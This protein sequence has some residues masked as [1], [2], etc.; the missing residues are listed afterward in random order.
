M[1]LSYASREK[2][3]EVWR[4]FW[5][6]VI[7]LEPNG[8]QIANTYSLNRKPSFTSTKMIF[9]KQLSLYKEN[10]SSKLKLFYGNDG[11]FQA[12]Q[13]ICIY[14]ALADLKMANDG[15]LIHNWNMNELRIHFHLGSFN[16]TRDQLYLFVIL[17][18][19]IPKFLQYLSIIKP[20]LDNK[21]QLRHS[22][23][24]LIAKW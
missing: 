13:I 5:L 7:I 6:R 20:T 12:N 15:I 17:C 14:L 4:W 10:I 2:W 19:S 11:V 24:L 23:Y 1:R 22:T 18:C 9:S 3:I 21:T 16:G 8:S